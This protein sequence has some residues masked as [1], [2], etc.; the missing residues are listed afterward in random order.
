MRSEIRTYLIIG[1]LIAG[2]V[3]LFPV[4]LAAAPIAV[5]A[6]LAV[7]GFISAGKRRLAKERRKEAEN[8]RAN[9]TISDA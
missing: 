3:V 2:A 5:V 7:Y 4:V 1:A 8:I 6:G 9:R